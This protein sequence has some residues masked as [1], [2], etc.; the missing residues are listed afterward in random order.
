MDRP[1]RQARGLLGGHDD[2]GVVRQEHDLLCP[3]P[4]HSHEQVGSRR[5]HRLAALDDSCRAEALEQ[6][7]VSL[8]GYDR[9]DRADRLRVGDRL[10]QPLLPLLGLDVHVG[11][12]DRFD[13]T[14]GGTERERGPGVVGVDVHP[15]RAGVADDEQRV[16]EPLELAL[17]GRRVEIGTLDHEARAVAELRQLLMHGLDR[18]VRG[19]RGLRELL[20]GD[21]GRETAHELQET[22]AARVDHARP[23][24]DVELLLGLRDGLLAAPHESREQLG[25]VEVGGGASLRLLGEGADDRQHRPLDGLADGTVRLVASGPERPCDRRGVDG[26]R[27]AELLGGAADDL[28]Q[29]HARVAARAHQRRAGDFVCQ[30]RAVCR[31]RGLES[32]GDALDR[33]REVRTG[34][35]VGH[36]VDVEVVDA[37][38]AALDRGAGRAH[39]LAERFEL[40][41]AERFTAWICTSTDA[42]GRPVRR[43]TS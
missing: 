2:V 27:P 33:E 38:P 5:V 14:G 20:S 22:G 8:P 40:A 13:H 29:D 26:P 17:Q 21:R 4:L 23:A 12:L 10:E 42:T 41:H 16:A 1:A 31:V 37:L 43:S 36:R 11:D 24:E 9:H 28:R 32:F 15:E 35:T 6:P 18:Q 34:V 19:G 7:P 3:R 30:L 25:G 39:Q